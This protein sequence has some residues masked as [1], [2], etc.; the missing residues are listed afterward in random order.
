MLASIIAIYNYD[1]TV[2]NPLKQYIP[3]EPSNPDISQ[4]SEPIDFETLKN[5]I[6][7]RAGELSLVYTDPR[8]LRIMIGTWGARNKLTWQHLFNSMYY[9]YDPLFSK[10]R[11]YTMNRG[12]SANINF[13]ETTEQIGTDTTDRTENENDIDNKHGTVNTVDVVD[14]NLT[15]S[16]TLDSNNNSV[17]TNYVQ[18]FDDVGVGHWHEHDKQTSN[19]TKQDI[20]KDNETT[21]ITDNKTETQNLIDEITKQI[22]ENV[23]KSVRDEIEKNHQRHDT[24]TINDIITETVHGQMPFQELIKL[25][26]EIVMF[27]LYDFIADEFVR[28]FCVMIY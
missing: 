14:S 20:T 1:D 8:L 9:K 16:G 5:T 2:L 12:T 26:R 19:D 18:A 11:E 7:F 25:Q 17:N 21:H 27:N 6:L 10:I 24:G 28:E 4:P 15:Q 23:T 3:I 22:T 13:T